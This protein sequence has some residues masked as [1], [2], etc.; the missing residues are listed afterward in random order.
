MNSVDTKAAIMK[1]FKQL[2]FDELKDIAN[3]IHLVDNVPEDSVTAQ[4]ILEALVFR[5]ER[6]ISQ[7]KRL[8]ALA[9]YPTEEMIWDE[10]VVPSDYHSASGQVLALPKLNLQFL[11]LHDYLLR[12]FELFRLESTCK[13]LC[14]SNLL[15]HFHPFHVSC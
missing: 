2:S 6:R 1:N 3:Q 5:Y 15:L 10:N 4:F 12:N 13:R 14:L 9:L 7:I 11:T 8:N